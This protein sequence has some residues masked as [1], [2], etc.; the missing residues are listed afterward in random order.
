M[1]NPLSRSEREQTRRTL[2]ATVVD[3]AH[4]T[5]SPIEWRRDDD[6]VGRGP[7][8]AGP[9]LATLCGAML[10]GCAGRPK[11]LGHESRFAE[12]QCQARY[13]IE[14]RRSPLTEARDQGAGISDFQGRFP[15]AEI[16]RSS[17]RPV[18]ATAMFLLDD[19]PIVWFSP[20]ND[21]VVVDGDA[22]APLRRADATRIDGPVRVG[23][24]TTHTREALGD[25]RVVELLM[26]AGAIGTY[27]QLG[28]DVCLE[29]ESQRE[30]ASQSRFVAVHHWAD[31]RMQE[32]RYSFSVRIDEGG[33]ITV[34]A[35]SQSEA[36]S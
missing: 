28:S 21:A 1:A 14:H 3:S 19:Q 11:P 30:G 4:A 2:R 33:V 12:G 13:V 17:Q 31:R 15:A 36:G 8:W 7:W 18:T 32:Q 16:D 9:A 6:L 34:S 22:F 20:A 25:R 29:A 23:R 10:L 26:R 27:R 35:D 5:A 24:V